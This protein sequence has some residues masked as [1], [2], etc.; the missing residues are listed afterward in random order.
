[1]IKLPTKKD[2]SK[3]DK[4]RS[5]YCTTIY[6]KTDEDSLSSQ[7]AN[8][9]RFK[10]LLSEAHK[11]MTKNGTSNKD[12][13]LHLKPAKN[14]LDDANFWNIRRRAIAAFITK[15]GVE[16][17]AS[18]AELTP[19]SSVVDTQ[20]DLQP[21]KLMMKNNHSYFVLALGHK[22]IQLLQ[23]DKYHLQDVTPEEL[24]TDMKETLNI[25]E[26]PSHLS[27]HEVAPVRGSKSNHSFHGQYNVKEEDKKDLINFFRI[28]DQRINGLMQKAGNPTL[29]LAGVDRLL[30]IYRQANTYMNLSRQQIT[31]NVRHMQEKDILQAIHPL[32]QKTTSTAS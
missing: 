25:D 22:D 23:G 17:Y 29:I 28:L 2:I 26:Q 3:L 20:Y 6:M 15:D 7:D 10:N 1:M 16:C 8:R 11:Q 27:S 14:L 31:K 24:P 19:N 4:I 13:E 21:L 9:I 12:A 18:P 5:E 32:L 30:P